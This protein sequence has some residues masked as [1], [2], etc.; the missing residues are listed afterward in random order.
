LDGGGVIE[1]PLQI[2]LLQK[3]VPG[4]FALY[5]R[6]I[7]DWNDFPDEVS[8]GY[9][10]WL[11][12]LAVRTGQPIFYSPHR[13]T[14]YRVHVGSQTSSFSGA[15]KRLRSLEY[16]L[17]IHKRMY[18]DTRLRAIHRDLSERIA[19]IHIS[20]GNALL[21]VGSRNCAFREFRSAAKIKPGLRSALG[22][23]LTLLPFGLGQKLAV[24]RS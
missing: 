22:L 19:G 11:T 6:S 7:M 12:Y 21:Q 17:F 15:D 18:A 5:R 20:T 23:G 4:M 9:D 8:S 24:L 14:S 16:N 1:S 13:L 3:A 2:A 10:F